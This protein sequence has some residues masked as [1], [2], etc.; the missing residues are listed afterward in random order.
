M[1]FDGF[2]IY[3][4][5]K[6]LNHSIQKSR[7]EKI[8]QKDES[9]FL[10]V[11]YIRKERHHLIIDLDPNHF[12]M[13]LSK[14]KETYQLGSQFLSTLKKHLEGAI[15]DEITQYASDRVI[16]CNFTVYDFILGPLKKML[17]F[18]AMGKHSNL[19][20][21]QDGM[22][23]DTFKKMFFE[24]GRQLLPQAT[25]QFF[26]TDKKPFDEIN[27]QEI[28]SSHDLVN[29]YMG[30]SPLLANYLI[31][32]PKQLHDISIQPTYIKN[33]KKS[34]VFDIFKDE[35][36]KGHVET[37]SELFE[38]NQDEKKPNYLSQR[39]FIQKQLKK[40][41]K[42]RELLH[43]SLEL[44]EEGLNERHIGDFIYASGLD[45]NEKHSEMDV[46]GKKIH[47]DATLTL[48]ENAQLHYKNYQKFKR[49]IKHIE[50]QIEE[51][52]ALIDLFANLNDFIDL[53]SE[54]TMKDFEKELMTYGYKAVKQKVIHKKHQQK[55]NYLYT[56]DS[57]ASYAVGKNNVQNEFLTHTYAN[58]EDYWFHVKDAPGAHV[59]V[60]TKALNEHVIRK[61]SM[62]AAYFSKLKASSSIPVDY[63]QIRHLKKIP[64]KPRYQVIYQQYKTMYIDIDDAL[65]L[66]AIQKSSKK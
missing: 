29:Q 17:I 15:L 27:Y 2:F 13:Y 26:P 6:E 36:E 11:F 41:E 66:E 49:S 53:Q 20:L 54:E 43:Q 34:Y 30:V 35:Q 58:K 52:E 61:A 38:L 47:L 33:S 18:E 56:E 9:S 37:I 28:K 32:H 55:P 7:L 65:I 39:Q 46:E 62:L 3:H 23:I 40:Y 48:N 44:S 1:T 5:I 63:T 57:F 45:L 60:Q 19:I 59:I 22:I 14:H 8:Y 31:E 42:K 21:V 24:T 25:F 16:I 12:G 64:G 51:N 10:C 4:L 50:S